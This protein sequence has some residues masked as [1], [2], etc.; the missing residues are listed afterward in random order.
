MTTFISKAD[1][2]IGQS[3]EY[4]LPVPL[5]AADYEGAMLYADSNVFFSD[6]VDWTRFIFSE[7]LD[8]FITEEDELYLEGF[9]E[10]QRPNATTNFTRKIYNLDTNLPEFSNGQEWKSLADISRTLELAEEGFN[11]Q[12]VVP[13]EIVTVGAAGDFAT[14]PEAIE[15]LL[16]KIPV[17]TTTAPQATIII[18]SGHV[19]NYQTS[20]FGVRAGWIE[21]IAEDEWVGV[22]ASSFLEKEDLVT[23]AR[24]VFSFSSGSVAPV[25]NFGISITNQPVGGN[26][27]GVVTQNSI[28]FV[29]PNKEFRVRNAQIGAEFN[30]NSQV[31]IDTFNTVNCCNGFIVDGSLVDIG[32]NSR[33]RS[34]RPASA[35]FVLQNAH[36]NVQTFDVRI[37]AGVN[38]SPDYFVLEGSTLSISSATLGAANIAFNTL[39][40]N[41]I[42]FRY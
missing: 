42:I 26:S 3:I 8:D 11:N 40:P 38:S 22:N 29:P 16:K 35:A 41:G 10:A 5:A 23:N 27:V 2:T 20:L 7:E 37:V 19:I 34:N 18:L 1:K 33:F 28:M 24:P 30:D 13:G 32:P 36:A 14:I 25:L 4:P 17:T 21:I 31:S 39:T 9:E 15:S 12:I 6:G